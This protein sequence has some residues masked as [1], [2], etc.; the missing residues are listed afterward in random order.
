MLTAH[1]R[2]PT[3]HG[4]KYLVQL[5]K[6]W[7][8]KFPDLTYTAERAD[9]PLPGA[10]CVLLADAGGLDI[11]LRSDSSETLSRVQSVVADHLKRFAHREA[12]TIDWAPAQ[13]D[14]NG[15]FG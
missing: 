12:L 9:I 14:P 8:H 1:A 5:S 7:A 15:S 13:Y 11:T 3:D 6:H 2:V 4:R 10:P